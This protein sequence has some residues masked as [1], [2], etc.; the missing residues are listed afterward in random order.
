M[1]I[2][3][4]LLLVSCYFTLTLT[5][6]GTTTTTTSSTATTPTTT[7]TVSTATTSTST[8]IMA[9]TLVRHSARGPLDNSY[10][11]L[12]QWN[13]VYQL[14]TD[15]GKRM[16]YVLGAVYMRYYSTLLSPFSASTVHV[17]STNYERTRDTAS[18][19]FQGAYNGPLVGSVFNANLA[20]P[21]YTQS[22]I[23][24]VL[25]SLSKTSAKFNAS[26]PVPTVYT[27]SSIILAAGR[28]CSNYETWVD[29]ND[30]NVAIKNVYNTYMLDLV[31]YLRTKKIYASS[32]EDLYSFADIAIS[33]YHAGL[34]IP[35]GI[36]PT[37]QYYQDLKLAYEWLSAIWYTAQTVQ[38][39]L[40]SID[41][42]QNILNLMDKVV[43][44]KSAIKF[45]M[46]SAHDVTL[47]PVLA[48]LGIVNDTCL[49][50]NYVATRASKTLPYPNCVFPGFTANIAFELYSSTTST[51]FVEVYYNGNLIKICNN[52]SSCGLTSFRTDIQT[53]T[54]YAYNNANFDT[55]CGN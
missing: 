2:N 22:T 35:G 8:L 47:L 41:T 24:S 43:A 39:Q 38:T 21:M 18:S 31:K 19:F 3:L 46:F 37:S 42:F 40:T 52:K 16:A 30:L 13:S 25:T 34:P 12:N 55:L 32:L 29:E 51:P 15:A 50:A 17:E 6:S 33:N 48:T 28:D 10:D 5:L 54:N 49:L 53:K 26:A 23:T 7:S 44:K 20:M 36:D 27:S 1:K 9:A 45:A 14:L 11:S 4:I